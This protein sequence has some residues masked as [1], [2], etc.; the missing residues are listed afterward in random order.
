MILINREF[1]ARAKRLVIEE[2]DVQTLTHLGLTISQAKVYL[3]LLALEKATGKIIA[4]HSKVAR[5]EAYRILDELQEKGLVEKIIDMPTEFK[6][7]PIE[8]CIHILIESKKNEISETQKKATSLLRKIKK[9][10]SHT[11]AQLQENASQFILVPEKEVIR[12]TRRNIENTQKSLDII[13]TLNRFKP[14]IFNFDEVDKKA[15]ERGVKFRLIINKPEDEN[16]LTEIVKA[17]TKNP[18]FDLRYIN[19]PPLAAIAIYDKRKMIIAISATAAINEV[20]MLMSNNP[21]LLAIVQSYF[22]TMW[23]TAMKSNLDSPQT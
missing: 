10:N 19:P 13:T 5:Q 2:E 6:P 11:K 1:L 12:R 21:S 22:E 4:K 23:L 9:K 7:I 17:V 18:L 3:T 15:L 16:S 14:G 20:P 8:D